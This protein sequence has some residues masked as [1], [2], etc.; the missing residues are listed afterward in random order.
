MVFTE[1]RGS[2]RTLIECGRDVDVLVTEFPPPH[3]GREEFY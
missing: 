1:R 3:F 2:D